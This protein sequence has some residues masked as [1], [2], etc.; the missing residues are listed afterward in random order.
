MKKRILAIMLCLCMVMTLLPMTALAANSEESAAQT[1]G[2][3]L[4]SAGTDIDKDVNMVEEPQAVWG[5]TEEYGNSGTLEEAFKALEADKSMYIKLQKNVQLSDTLIV[6][7]ADDV[8][9][10]LAGY[11][12]TAAE[13]KPILVITDNKTFTLNDSVGTGELTGGI[14]DSHT[15]A[16]G[17]TVSNGATFNLNGGAITG[18]THTGEGYGTGGVSLGKNA[19]FIMT[20]GSITGNKSNHYYGGVNAGN[21]T[22]TVSGNAVITGNK[23]KDFGEEI[24]ANLWLNTLNNKLLNIGEAGF[25]ENALIGITTNSRN[26]SNDFAFT[27]AY[28]SGKASASNFISDMKKL[29]VKEIDKD[30]QKQ[31]AVAYPPAAD[32]TASLASGTYVGPRTVTLSTESEGA[33]L[34]QQ[35]NLGT[36]EW[37]TDPITIDKD[38]VIEA[39]AYANGSWGYSNVSKFEYTII[40]KPIVTLTASE[41]SFTGGKTITLTVNTVGLTEDDIVNFALNGAEE[42][43]VTDKGNGV[44]EVKIPNKTAKYQFTATVSGSIS[45]G[46]AFES[47]TSE[48]VAV[49]VKKSGGSSSGN[50]GS[51]TYSISVPSDVKNG[52]VSVSPKSAGSDSS[53]TIT[54]KPDEGYELSK[55]TATDKNGKEIKL[56]DEGDGKYTFTMPASRV[57]IDASFA[58]IETTLP[59]TDAAKTAW[60]YDAV[61]YVYEN[62]MMNGTDTE[63][64]SPD[65]NTS[66]GMI[67]TILYRLE[68]EPAVADNCPF[69]D[70]KADSYY[71]DAIIW[72]A[73]NGIVNGYSE[74]IYGPDDAIT[75]EQ[76]AAILY[77]YADYKGYDVTKKA[78]L[79][80]F[81]D[82]NEI[83]GYA[84]EALAWANANGIMNG[85]GDGTLNPT[86]TATRAEAAQ[87]LMNFC[88]NILK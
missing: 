12:V 59:F 71:E 29:S 65:F 75:R 42:L 70:V 58:K 26:F 78:D 19:N 15:Y 82:Q 72:A 67:V 49:D 44:F 60:Y 52:S 35:I 28:D 87:M 31:M 11:T 68:N 46:D 69:T 79:S 83:S 62:G 86:G 21:G 7:K 16:A 33:W 36:I 56:T 66:R 13:N 10:D 45:G 76:L 22:V 77:R 55:L 3:A 14:T 40:D 61:K 48:P 34:V 23:G 24:D 64:F 18:N 73:S 17:V 32:P 30:G 74:S 37:Y 27:A 54:V 9:L 53:V 38:T 1:L 81:A 57:D 84:A 2:K 50:S 39:W 8:T 4:K 47:G 51:T 43:T 20:G 80:K 85:N 5:E 63:K 88:K 25:G 6:E 41:T